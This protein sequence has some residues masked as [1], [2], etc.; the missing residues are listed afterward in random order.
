MSAELIQLPWNILLP[1]ACGYAGYFVAHIGVR[2]HH[3]SID[4]TFATLVYGFIGMLI[5][6]GVLD[7]RWGVIVSSCAAFLGT[8]VMGGAWN[9]FGRAWSLKCLRLAKVSYNDDLPTAW[10]SLFQ[11][12]QTDA[13]QLAVRLTDGTWMYCDNLHEFA[14][15]PN[16]PCVLGVEGDVLM[17]VTRKVRSAIETEFEVALPDWGDDITYI[18][19]DSIS[20]L[21]L[22]RKIRKL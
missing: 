18:P 8:I 1:L 22:R 17:Y 19:A 3:K 4:V 9:S 16:G 20:Q 2:G 6:Q 12:D 7:N 5:Y 11:T 14:H 15:K 13:T 10:L 21:R